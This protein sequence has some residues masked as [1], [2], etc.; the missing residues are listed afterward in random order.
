MR[1]R[2]GGGEMLQGYGSLCGRGFCHRKLLLYEPLSPISG[3]TRTTH[4]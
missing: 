4:K 1:F 2:K 3:E